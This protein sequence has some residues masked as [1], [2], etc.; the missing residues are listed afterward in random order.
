MEQKQ[1]VNPW[2]EMWIK[3]KA[4]LRSILD[5][6]CRHG[7]FQICFLVGLVQLLR[8]FQYFSLATSLPLWGILALALILAV[9][10]GFVSLNLSTLFIYL[11]GK[12]FKGKGSYYEVRAAVTWPNVTAIF[13]LIFIGVLVL[14]FQGDF[15]YRKFI[16]TPFLLSTIVFFL[17]V[18]L[19]IW[20]IVL[21]V[22]A[23]S[24]AQ[25]FSG[26]RSV[27]NLL[28]ATIIY[29][30]L[31]LVVSTLFSSGESNLGLLMR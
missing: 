2:W 3:P 24:E 28:L 25:G 6:N 22:L 7:F 10:C 9:P 5:T 4:T 15:F 23:L 8:L 31:F 30:V 11:T 29:A 19:G 26:G 13:S 27:L 20:N 18:V 14:T 12:L 17:D 1:A 21:L 16:E